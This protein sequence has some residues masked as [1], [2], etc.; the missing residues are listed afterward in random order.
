MDLKQYKDFKT[1]SLINFATGMS[2]AEAD[3]IL[4]EK[5]MYSRLISELKDMKDNK[6]FLKLVTILNAAVAAVSAVAAIVIASKS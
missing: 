1:N 2:K 3:K 6:S 5:E 4:L